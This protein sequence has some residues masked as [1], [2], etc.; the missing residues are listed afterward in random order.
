MSMST[1]RWSE[2]SAEH[3]VRYTG[4]E[5][6]WV[7]TM[8]KTGSNGGVVWVGSCGVRAK[9]QTGIPVGIIT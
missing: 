7:N 5:R 2:L 1:G 6:F 4:N 3:E 8:S 9:D